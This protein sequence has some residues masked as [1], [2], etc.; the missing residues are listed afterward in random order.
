M[1]RRWITA[2][3]VIVVAG[4]AGPLIYGRLADSAEQ[5]RS[6]APGPSPGAAPPPVSVE[7]VQVSAG[8]ISDEITAVGTLSSNESVV[9]RPEIAGRISTIRMEEGRAVASGTDLITIDDAL[10][11]AELAEARAKVNLAESNYRRAVELYERRAASASQRD[12]AL[13]RLEI[14]RATLD[15]AQVRLEKTR[16]LAPFA[17]I[18]GLRK[19]SV[20]SYVVPG[21]DLVNLE[22]INPLK[23]DFRIPERSLSSLRSGQRIRVRVDAFPGEEFPGEIYALDPLVDPQG[24][25]VALRARIRNDDQKLRPGLFARVRVIVEERADALLVPEQALVPRGEERFV[26][27]VVDGKAVLT[28]VDIGKR[29][30]G[31]VEITAGVASGD[32]VVTAGQM[33]LRDGSPVKVSGSSKDA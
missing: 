31:N 2:L 22:S 33:K 29:M 6:Q 18:L 8:T 3:L 9:I 7:A 14:D 20:G 15:L 10:Y 23:V 28:R 24:R 5:T 4:A 19:V 17:G 30:D 27:R 25:S 16:I 26:F 32:L 21:Q 13:A 11:R 12:E 1:N